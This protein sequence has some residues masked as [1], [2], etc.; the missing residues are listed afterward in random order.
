MKQGSILVIDDDPELCE[1]LTELLNEK[2]YTVEVEHDGLEGYVKAAEGKYDMVLLDVRLPTIDGFEVLRRLRKKSS[3]PILMLTDEAEEVDRVKGLELGSDDY[4]AKPFSTRELTARIQAILKRSLETK[5]S[6]PSEIIIDDLVLYPAL[7]QVR[8]SSEV[9]NLT[10]AEFLSLQKLVEAPNSM[11]ERGELTRHALDRDSYENDRSI[12]VH[13]SNL[14]KKLGDNPDGSNRIKTV[15][16][17]GYYY[18]Q[19]L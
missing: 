12:D 3:I 5:I 1:I 7:M 9:I 19:P 17:A 16:G 10:R 14:R 13:I 8:K 18:V 6:T 2:G 4:L 11:I 15:R